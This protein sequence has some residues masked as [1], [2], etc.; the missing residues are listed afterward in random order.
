MSFIRIRVLEPQSRFLPPMDVSSSGAMFVWTLWV[1]CWPIRKALNVLSSPCSTTTAAYWH[2][3]RRSARHAQRMARVAAHSCD[4]QANTVSPFLPI[5]PP[6]RPR[7]G[8]RH[9]VMKK[10]R[11]AATTWYMSVDRIVPVGGKPLFLVF[12]VPLDELLVGAQRQTL[13]TVGFTLLVVLAA[14]PL[15]WL[16]ARAISRP[17]RGLAGEAEAIRRFEFS[18]TFV[19]QS[20]VSEV[21][22]LSLAMDE[23]RLA[24]RR[25]LDI[26]RA[27]AAEPH[28]DRLL[29]SP[30]CGRLPRQAQQA[31]GGRS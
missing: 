27:M 5:W 7:S 9:L 18:E 6:R 26:T 31:F 3:A 21:N 8:M 25:F 12:A 14:M 20:S 16:F 28:L 11:S 10:Q 4:R 23:M 13:A 22:T 29:P 1:R 17:L 15:S 30:S 24:I 2:P 19:A